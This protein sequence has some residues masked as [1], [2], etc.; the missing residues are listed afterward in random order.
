MLE[1]DKYTFLFT[2]LNLL[3][4]YLLMKKFLFKPVTDF[5]EKRSGSIQ[6]A[7]DNA[8]KDK[9]EAQNL[10]QKYEEQIVR[11]KDEADEILKEARS[12]AAREHDDMIFST[13]Q[14]AERILEKA[15]ED[16][17]VERAQMMKE[18]RGE[19]AGIALLAA[20]KVI[21]ANMDTERNRELVNKFIDEEGAA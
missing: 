20:S 2:A 12:R 7:L 14:E 11:A 21:E 18:L 13:R 3:V 19:I 16:I 5:M 15:R 17:S 9:A 1:L 8:K 6:D 10:K 4:L